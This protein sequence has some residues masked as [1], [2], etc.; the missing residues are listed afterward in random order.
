MFSFYRKEDGFLHIVIGILLLAAI[1]MRLLN[2][3]LFH[4]TVVPFPALLAASIPGLVITWLFSGWLR[5]RWPRTGSVLSCITQVFLYVCVA[6]FVIPSLLLTPFKIIDPALLHLD[7]RI[8]FSTVAFMQWTFSHP[9]L[10]HLLTMSYSTW[11]PEL[12]LTPIVLAFFKDQLEIDRY[13]LATFVSFFIGGLI[14]YFWPTIAPAGVLHNQR[15]LQ[16]QYD[17]ILR[18]QQVH[19]H[20]PVTTYDGGLISFPSFHVITALLV[21]Y[22]FRKYAPLFYPLLL[23]NILL[24]VSTMALGYHYVVDVIAALI[25]APMSIWM[26]VKINKL[27]FEI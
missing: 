12:L 2:A 18:F 13:L 4:Y 14:Y 26:A 9:W 23:L 3:H 10:H 11:M 6:A 24:I 25:L 7:Q 5:Q 17:L 21:L 1:V 22:A 19:Q 16:E 20:I 8:G 15:F 27:K